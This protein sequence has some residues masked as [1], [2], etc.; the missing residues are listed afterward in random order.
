MPAALFEPQPKPG[1]SR[2]HT[3]RSESAVPTISSLFSLLASALATEAAVA[4][5]QGPKT[6]HLV[7][8]VP[9]NAEASHWRCSLPGLTVAD[10]RCDLQR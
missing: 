10:A 5:A 3:H 9:H 2:P 4:N 1:L 8:Q 6:V 7:S